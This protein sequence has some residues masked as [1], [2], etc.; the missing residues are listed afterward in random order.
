MLSDV[1]VRMG[2]CD[3]ARSLL[4]EALAISGRTGEVWAQPE[5]YRHLAELPGVGRDESEQRFWQAI[6]TARRHGAKLFEL[7]AVTSLARLWDKCG[8]RADALGLLAPIYGQFSEPAELPD[9]IEARS[10]LGQLE[11]ARA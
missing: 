10:M 4:E 11:L 6:E 2:R 3:E 5:L 8:R 1:C 7:R 9:F